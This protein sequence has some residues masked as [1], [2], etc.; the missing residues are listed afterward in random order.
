MAVYEASREEEEAT[1]V[2]KM[3][4]GKISFAYF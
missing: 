1:M 4:M 2:T 3:W